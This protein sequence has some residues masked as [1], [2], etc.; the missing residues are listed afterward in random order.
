M[1]ARLCVYLC[2]CTRVYVHVSL[3]T[4][5]C[6]CELPCVNWEEGWGSNVNTRIKLNSPLFNNL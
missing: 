4:G 6:V 1:C 2:V 3:I 5:L